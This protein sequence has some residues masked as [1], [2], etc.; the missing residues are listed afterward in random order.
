MI[1]IDSI[2]V[3][4]P[5]KQ[6]PALRNVSLHIKPNEIVG[7]AGESGSGKTTLGKAL[8][9]LL[10]L[11]T[12]NIWYDEKNIRLLNKTERFQ[13]CREFQMIWQDP[14]GSLNPRMRIGDIISEGV[15]I[16]KLKKTLPDDLVD[17]WLH[18]VGLP[19]EFK[20]RYPSTL[21]GGQRQRVVIARALAVSPRFLVCDEPVS[22]L[23][24]FTQ[25]QILNLLK[26]IKNKHSLSL[27]FIS[28]DL[29]VLSE[30]CDR[31]AI[32]HQGEIVECEQAQTLLK[33]P[34]H[35]YTRALIS[36][37]PTIPNLRP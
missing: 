31:I 7:V 16:H 34:K 24:L 23:D 22:A 9:G 27:L 29:G 37:I 30:I 19:I 6:N 5:R 8:I 2:S 14:Y 28:H 13:L 10:P 18:A 25:K 26:E 3:A 17:H 1:R 36:S 12:G 21:S 35:P 33:N 4:Y 11:L 32:L 15:D 20:H